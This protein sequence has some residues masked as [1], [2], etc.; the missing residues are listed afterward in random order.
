MPEFSGGK[1]NN[2]ENKINVVIH[3]NNYLFVG[4]DS[5][6]A[7]LER[8]EIIQPKKTYTWDCA[9]T[10]MRDY[11]RAMRTS[12]KISGIELTPF[13]MLDYASVYLHING[14][15]RYTE[16]LPKWS[17]V[18]KQRFLVDLIDYLDQYDP[19]KKRFPERFHA[20]YYELL[21]VKY[22]ESDRLLLS[23]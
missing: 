22:L 3:R 15:H 18:R 13:L 11:Y 9:K 6:N 12:D 20:T 4:I 5:L 17:L 16:L 2:M 10:I 14:I 8:R 23:N 7:E 1:N 21:N 19:I